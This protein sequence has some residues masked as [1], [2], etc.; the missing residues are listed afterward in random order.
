MSTTPHPRL[1]ELLQG[2]ERTL[3]FTGAGIST[4]SGIPDYRGPGGLWTQQQPVYYQ[5]F[6]ASEEAR[7]RYWEM[8]RAGWEAYRDARPNPVHHAVVHLERRGKLDMVVTQNIDGLHVR[9]GTSA[10][11]LVELHGTNRAIECQTCGDRSDP[12]PHYARFA[13][14]GTAPRC[15]CGGFLKS[16]T[17]SFGQNLRQDDLGRAME[18][19]SRA[20]L[21]VALGSTLSVTPAAT[22]PLMAAEAG[23]PYVI[24]N[25]GETAHDG[26][27][28]LDTRIEGDVVEA[29]PPAVAAA[30]EQG[31]D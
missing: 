10:D 29:F 21:V 19:A 17:I 31:A 1:V 5:D 2:A 24:I 13:A 7:A 28:G 18:A 8:A 20:D 15:A 22:I 25:R 3:I 14:T 23:A 30:L 11:H 27:P 12:E 16:A 9:A 26:Y 4:G 6:L